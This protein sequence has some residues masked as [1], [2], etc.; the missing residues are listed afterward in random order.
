MAHWP[1]DYKVVTS[2]WG[3][4]RSGHHD[5]MDI[6]NPKG[7][8]VY[9]THAGVVNRTY[10]AAKGGNQIVIHNDDGSVSGYA[11]TAANVGAGQ[12]IAEGQLIGHSDSSGTAQPHLHYTYRR[13]QSCNKEDPQPFLP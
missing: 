13:C 4:R 7:G 9:A 3:S 5:G 2:P 12:K 1:T 10:Y 11:H 8:K 6:R